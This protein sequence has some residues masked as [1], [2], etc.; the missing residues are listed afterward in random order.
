MMIMKL[1]NSISTT[2]FAIALLLA[3]SAHAV[4]PTN[5]TGLVGTW[6]NINPNTRGTVK[7]ELW[8]TRSGLRF[9]SYG[10]CSPTPCV[11]SVVSAQPHSAGVSSNTAVG[12]TAF[13]NSG[14]KYTRYS[15]SRYGSYLRLDQFS[16]FASGDSRKNYTTS[17]YFRR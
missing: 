9:R 11:H 7:V 3:T 4:A 17:E 6:H 14:F 10:S 5:V 1:F 8:S 12:F 16:T 2:S 15:G 13:R